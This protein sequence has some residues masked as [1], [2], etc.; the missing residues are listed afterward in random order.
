MCAFAG[1]LELA[2]V[3]D[4]EDACGLAHARCSS[5]IAVYWT[6]I[7]HPANGTRRAPRA[8]WRS[9]RG[10]RRRVCT[11]RILSVTE[12]ADTSFLSLEWAENTRESPRRKRCSATSTSRSRRRRAL[13]G[14]TADFYCECSDVGC[15]TASV[16]LRITRKCERGTHFIVARHEDERVER[17]LAS[18]RYAVVDKVPGRRRHRHAARSAHEADACERPEAR[19]EVPETGAPRPSRDRGPNRRRREPQRRRRRPARAGATCR[20]AAARRGGRA[21]AADAGSPRCRVAPRP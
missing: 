20:R 5:V 6:G 4:V 16:P 9:Y 13:R 14:G 21:R 17:V 10:V 1:E 12:C 8:A 19:R 7:S 3:R 11:A 15:P 2:H 18:S